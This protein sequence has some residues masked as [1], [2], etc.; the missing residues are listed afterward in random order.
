MVERERRMQ[1]TMKRQKG[2]SNQSRMMDNLMFKMPSI[3]ASISNATPATHEQCSP[4]VPIDVCTD[5]KL[6]THI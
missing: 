4:F 1:S 2:K 5:T 6:I 3:L